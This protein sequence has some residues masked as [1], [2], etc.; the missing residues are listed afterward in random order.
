MIKVLRSLAGTN[1]VLVS[2]W[3]ESYNLRGAVNTQNL[4]SNR[5]VIKDS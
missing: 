3:H 4:Q 1:I 5:K 2:T